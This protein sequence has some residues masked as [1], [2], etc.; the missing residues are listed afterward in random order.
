MEVHP[1]R[2]EQLLDIIASTP[3][4]DAKGKD[5]RYGI[6]SRLLLKELRKNKIRMLAFTLQL[7]E[8]GGRPENVYCNWPVHAQ[9]VAHEVMLTDYL[10]ALERAFPGIKILR[11]Y[12]VDPA[13]R[14][15]ADVTLTKLRYVELDRGTEKEPQWE[16]RAKVLAKAGKGVQV[17]TLT[18]ARMERLK[19]WSKKDIADI[20]FFALWEEAVRNPAGAIWSTIGNPQKLVMK[21]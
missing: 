18:E 19:A 15:D 9:Q 13:V 21:P 10:L 8:W 20:A 17:L 7:K 12:D 11:G 14:A 16:H 2:K 1:C 3:L 6:L 4:L 5:K